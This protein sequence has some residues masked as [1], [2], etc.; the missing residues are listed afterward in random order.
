MK[1]SKLFSVNTKDF[2]KGLIMSVLTPVFVIIEQSVSAGSLTFDWK[3]IT[4]AA[5]GGFLGYM[6]KN[7]FTPAK[8]EQALKST[9]EES[10]NGLTVGGRPNDRNP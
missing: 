3:F 8:T 9:D 1:D 4:L 7:F 5:I 6:T 2:L 10:P